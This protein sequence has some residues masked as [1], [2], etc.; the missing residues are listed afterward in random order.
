[1]NGS[2]SRI[3]TLKVTFESANNFIIK[4]QNGLLLTDRILAERNKYYA[5]Q[6]I[7][8]QITVVITLI[9]YKTVEPGMSSRAAFLNRRVATR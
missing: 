6:T 2:V 8:I 5:C 3:N 7:W 4:E 1:M 9:Q